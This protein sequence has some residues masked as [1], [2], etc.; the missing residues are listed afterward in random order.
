MKLKNL[1]IIKT[2]ED[3]KV[4]LDNFMNSRPGEWWDN[5]YSDKERNIPFYISV[6]DENLIQYIES[7]LLNIGRALDIGCGNG[8]NSLFLAKK[9]F[10]VVGIDLSSESISYANE[11]HTHANVEFKSISFFDLE[12][13]KESFDFI[14]DGGCLHHI[15]PH[16]RPEYLRKVKLLLNPGG[17]YGME[18]FNEKGGADL[19]DYQV[20][21]ERSMKGGLAFSKEKLKGIL[22]EYFSI[23][24][25]REM[26][27]ITDNTAF[28]KSFCWAVLMEK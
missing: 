14:Y 3:M 12:Y 2:D 5:F 1:D 24:E 21:E 17:N 13:D 9:G 25:L 19:T 16:R 8:R 4:L 22:S 11:H 15:S 7:G 10:T 6:P 27:E 20:Y 28:G 18:I 26:K 23:L